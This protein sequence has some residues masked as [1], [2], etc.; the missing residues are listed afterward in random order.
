MWQAK[1]KEGKDRPMNGFTPFYP[2]QFETFL[3]TAKL[4]LEMLEPMHGFGRVVTH[5]SGFCIMAGILALHDAG[6]VGQS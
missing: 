2:S 3:T 1:I 4:M 6:V 5:D